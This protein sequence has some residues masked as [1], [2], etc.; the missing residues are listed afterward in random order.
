MVRDKCFV[1]M[2]F[3][4]KH[5]PD[6]IDKTFDFDKIYRTIIRR[7]VQEAGMEA[8]RADE[9]LGSHII[10][11]DMFR[12]LR[13][14]AVVLADLSLGNP[15]VYYE[16]GIRH[17]LSS[18][19]TVLMCREGT[20]LPFDVRLSRVVFYKYDGVSIDWEVV[21]EVVPRLKASLETAKERKPDSPVH[22]LLE[23][24]YP[25]DN[26]KVNDSS[27]YGANSFMSVQD[28]SKYEH[29]VAQ[30]WSKEHADIKELIND[31]GNNVFGAR[32]LG[33]FCLVNQ[34]RGENIASV[35]HLLYNHGQYDMSCQLFERL[36]LEEV[37]SD[38]YQL[39]S[40]DF[41][42][43]G[44]AVSECDPTNS[45]AE[46]GLRLMDEALSRAGSQPPAKE[47][48]KLHNG[49]A[50]LLMWKWFLSNKQEIL[51]DAISHLQTAAEAA[52]EMQRSNDPLPLGGIGKL[53]LRLLITLRQRD[54]SKDRRDIERCR[55][56]ILA[57]DES[58]AI[59][60][61]DASW[62]R[63]YKTIV[64]ADT[65]R[66]DKVH[67]SILLAVKE[68]SILMQNKEVLYLEIGR[69]QYTIL[70]RF[71]EHNLPYLRHH[72]LMGYISQALQYASQSTMK[73]QN[74]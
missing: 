28:F 71:I 70:R 4:I 13:D 58:K 50:G 61:R 35:A 23:R 42:Y 65:G 12:E 36:H 54:G 6:E 47:Q 32:A 25:E 52:Q 29:S 9:Q 34:V 73:Y 39:T 67:E 19:G 55:D 31:H 17:V 68:D 26:W 57:L 15:N 59:D 66:E 22:A 72:T 1:I 33:E 51:L 41:M 56:A 11:S 37:K 7:A 14:R 43:Y 49:I 5:I 45:G 3:G 40:E 27:K 63:W 18:S 30:L 8:I 48:L 74:H 60:F 24:V 21:E 64:H 38:A 10:H 20:E 44:S 2:P 62:V 69:R 16:L 53:Y 46:A